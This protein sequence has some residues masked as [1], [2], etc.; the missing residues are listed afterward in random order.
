MTV[1]I[2]ANGQK[3]SGWQRG[4]IQLT[5]SELA[6]SFEV[7]YLVSGAGHKALEPGDKVQVLVN[8]HVVLDGYVDTTDDEDTPEDLRLKVGGRSRTAD[9]VD[10]SAAKQQFSRLTVQQIAEKIAAPF[11]V[12]VTLETRDDQTLEPFS[13]FSVQQ[14]ETCADAILRLCQARGLYP[15]AV[16]T[17]LALGRAG[18]VKATMRLVRGSRPLLRTAKSDSW[19]SRY[20][21]YVFRGQIR[22]TEER[23]GKAAAA[24]K[25]KV[26]DPEITRYR[27]LLIQ[28]EAH[29][30]GELQTRAEVARNQRI[31][32][33][34]RVTVSVHG[35]AMDDG[36]PWRANML[37][38]VVHPVLDV[39]ETLLISVVRMRFGEAE[40][41]ETELEL[42]PPMAF[43]IGKNKVAK[44]KGPKKGVYTKP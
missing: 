37:I 12:P 3:L 22:A 8:G 17:G 28:V 7:E 34:Q 25:S 38:D 14:G 29:G 24:L 6:N 2:S 44:E 5:M 11:G 10:C 4:T 16:G 1:E 41:E 15:Y 27:P 39:N 33:G 31:G 19:Y 43:D 21:E 40:A 18:S 35:L 9:L 23:A 20:S 13:G 26:T 36:Q 32:A 30:A 42:V